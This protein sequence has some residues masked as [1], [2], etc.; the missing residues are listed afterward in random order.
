LPDQTNS[1]SPGLFGW[2]LGE[3]IEPTKTVLVTEFPAFLPYSWHEPRLI[4][5]EAEGVNNARNVVTFADGHA[6][7]IKIYW[8]SDYNVFTC[9]YDPPAGYD[10]KWSAD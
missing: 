2:K 6:D 3:I 9:F 1:N 4:P 7:Y 5:D 8:D 10:Y